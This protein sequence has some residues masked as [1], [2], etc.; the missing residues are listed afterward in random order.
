MPTA[1]DTARKTTENVVYIRH[2]TG[3]APHC[4]M[5]RKTRDFCTTTHDTHKYKYIYLYMNCTSIRRVN[6]QI[7]YRWTI[8]K[9]HYI[10]NNRI[11]ALIIGH[12]LAYLQYAPLWIFI[13]SDWTGRQ[14]NSEWNEMNDHRRRN[15]IKS[16][17]PR[18]L[19]VFCVCGVYVWELLSST[20]PS[21]CE[22]DEFYSRDWMKSFECCVF[23]YSS[24]E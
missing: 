16:A 17:K 3:V 2:Y 11:A 18:L 1:A 10:Y 7:N 24:S 23:I 13:T 6:I 22:F 19:V 4:A 5:S 15:Q 20:W 12:W 9:L 21:K 8:W 14:I